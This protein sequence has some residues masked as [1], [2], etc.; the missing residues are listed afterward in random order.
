[1][2][3]LYERDN[4]FLAF[5]GEAIEF[6]Q[7]FWRWSGGGLFFFAREEIFDSGT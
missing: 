5:R 1:M 3:E 4:L 7:E 6:D 2:F